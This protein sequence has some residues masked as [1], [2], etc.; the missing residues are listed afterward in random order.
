MDEKTNDGDEH[1]FLIKSV[2]EAV[3]AFKYKQKATFDTFTV[4]VPETNA[5]NLKDFE[6]LATTSDPQ[7]GTFHPIGLFGQKI[8][9]LMGRLIKCSSSPG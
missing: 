2:A 7:I 6:L 9:N 3:Y 4:F 5:N 8:W 1:K